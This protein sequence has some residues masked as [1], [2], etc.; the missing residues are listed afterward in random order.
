MLSFFDSMTSFIST[1]WGYFQNFLTL[2]LEMLNFL[3]TSTMAIAS[4][5]PALPMMLSLGMTCT[6]SIMIVRFVLLK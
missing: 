1:I 2:T 4:I 3:L 5:Q 6:L